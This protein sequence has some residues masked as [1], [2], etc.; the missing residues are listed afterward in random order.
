MR[1]KRRGTIVNVSSVAGKIAIPFA[2]PYCASKHALEA[3]SDALRVEVAPFGIRVA[4]IEAGP[5]ETRFGDRARAG[6][7]RM[8]AAPGPYS[9][10]YRNAER[11]MDTDFQK[12]RLPPEAVARVILDAIESDRPRTRFLITR[13]ARALILL[14]RLLPDR[15]FDRR[16]KKVLKLPDRV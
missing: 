3:F 5:I 16:M 2:A 7:A 13:M 10:F 12:G 4:V 14:K 6:V 11:A 15:F 9:L 8:L 1:E